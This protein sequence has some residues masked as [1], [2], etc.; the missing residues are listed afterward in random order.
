M[1]ELFNRL[2]EIRIPTEDHLTLFPEMV[3]PLKDRLNELIQGWL[4]IVSEGQTSAGRP[5]LKVETQDPNNP[6]NRRI[7]YVWPRPN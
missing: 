6:K 3:Q 7:S 1:K 4:M 2:A 5:I